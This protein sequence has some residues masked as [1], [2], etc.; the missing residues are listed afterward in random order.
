MPFFT[1]LWCW[2]SVAEAHTVQEEVSAQE[3]IYTGAV[4]RFRRDAGLA[5]ALPGSLGFLGV[6]C[7]A[8]ARGAED[9]LVPGRVAP[10]RGAFLTLCQGLKCLPCCTRCPSAGGVWNWKVFAFEYNA[11]ARTG[12]DWSLCMSR[13]QKICFFPSIFVLSLNFP[14]WNTPFLSKASDFTALFKS[15]RVAAISSVFLTRD[16]NRFSSGLF[17][18]WPWS[19]ICLILWGISFF[20]SPKLHIKVEVPWIETGNGIYYLWIMLKRVC[21]YR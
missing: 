7:R 4:C 10:T 6:P 18:S 15:F 19:I 14:S 11:F 9:R 20:S 5:D 13:G 8:R 21:K 16:S 12:F 2:T 17:F 3:S 1:T